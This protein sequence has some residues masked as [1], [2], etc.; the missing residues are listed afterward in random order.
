MRSGAAAN[1]SKKYVYYDQLL[2][3][4][5]IAHPN[6]TEDSL[7]NTINEEEIS[8][9]NGTPTTTKRKTNEP[10]IQTGPKKRSNR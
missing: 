7:D 5:K 2:F 10:E 1:H 4:K 3:L 9:S 8:A 6:E